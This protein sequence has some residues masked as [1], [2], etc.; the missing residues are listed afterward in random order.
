M[1]TPRTSRLRFRPYT[2]DDVNDVY[3]L[4]ADPYARRYYPKSVDH[5]AAEGWI[6]WNLRNYD[7]HGFGL[8]ALE[9]RETGE[10]VGDCGITMQQVDDDK[11]HEVGYHVV[12]R[13]RRRGLATEAALA[14]RDWA[15]ETLGVPFVCSIV[16]AENVASK[17]VAERIHE[18]SRPLERKGSPHLLYY[19]E[20]E[21]S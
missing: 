6:R 18:K 9:L 19:T 4:F 13:L 10:F 15:L 11:K 3:E 21:A 14:C 2:L 7:E 12:E 17:R 1:E 20:R 5:E 16:D 8:W